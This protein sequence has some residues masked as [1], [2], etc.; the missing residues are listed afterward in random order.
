MPSKNQQNRKTKVK[1]ERMW[2]YCNLIMVFRLMFNL[3]YRWFSRRFLSK[4]PCRSNIS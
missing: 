4:R 3:S 2:S 1:K